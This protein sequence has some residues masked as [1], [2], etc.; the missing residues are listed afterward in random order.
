MALDRM[1]LADSFAGMRSDWREALPAIDGSDDDGWRIVRANTLPVLAANGANMAFVV[2]PPSRKRLTQA[3]AD[4]ATSFPRDVTVYERLARTGVLVV[5]PIRTFEGGITLAG[6]S[7]STVSL[8]LENGV[9]VVRKRLVAHGDGDP[10]REGRQRQE[11]AWMQNIPTGVRDLFV[12]VLGASDGSVGL[13]LVTE[14]V[15]GYSLAEI[16]FQHQIDGDGLARALERIYCEIGARVWTRPPIEMNVPIDRGDYLERIQRRLRTIEVSRSGLGGPL[17]KLLEAER[18]IVNG[19]ECDGVGRLL[20][21]LSTPRWRHAIMPGPARMCHGDLIL[22][23]IVIDKRAP[24]G[25]RLVDP[26]PSNQHPMYDVFKT[27]MSLWLKYEFFYFDRFSISHLSTNASHVAVEIRIDAPQAEAIYDEAAERFVAFAERELAPQLGF[28][29]NDF[30][31]LVRM[32]AA[33]NMLA[34]PVFHLLHHE[35]EPRALAF[36]AVA[37]H[38]AER[39]TRESSSPRERVSG[40]SHLLPS[41][42]S[43]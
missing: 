4:L 33:I 5:G 23:D 32:G 1:F 17:R 12:P 26:N 21:R 35:R 40:G 15:P 13:E 24:A 39:A 3:L 25:F 36:A 30:R 22:D 11:C 43:S 19:H 29:S 27:M 14:F 38:H 20:E 28:P 31:S 2:P 42:R 41:T 7:Y 37:L 10:D 8:H 9:P 16:V 6:G 18:V 34:I